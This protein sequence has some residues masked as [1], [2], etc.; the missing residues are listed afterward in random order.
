MKEKI[1]HYVLDAPLRAD[2]SGFSRWGF[3]TYKGKEYFVK[4][5]LSPV[6]PEDEELVGRERSERMKE[7]C[8]RY[9]TRQKLLYREINRCSANFSATAA[10][11]I[12]LQKRSKRWLWRLCLRFHGENAC[13]SAAPW[14]TV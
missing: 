4:E 13:G 10:N 11:T 6:Y 12:F 1:G 8:G 9:E 5:F 14:P 2:H 7:M 3:G